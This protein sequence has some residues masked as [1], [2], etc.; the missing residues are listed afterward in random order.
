VTPLFIISDEKGREIDGAFV[1]LRVRNG[2]V[3]SFNMVGPEF[4]T[5]FHTDVLAVLNTSSNETA[6]LP[7]VLMQTPKVSSGRQ[8]K[9][10]VNPAFGISVLRE[11]RLVSS[12]I[13]KKGESLAFDG[14]SIKFADLDYWASFYV[15]KEHG[16]GIVYAGF[17]FMTMALFIRFVFFRRDIRGVSESGKL[18]IA[19]R[20]EF[21]PALFEDEFRDII[22]RIKG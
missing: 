21:F 15:G 7:Q 17:I 5:I 22:Q 11:G 4:Q 20:A 1:K 18:H 16:L 13:L 9:E 10:I 6:N 12:G 2:G 14:Y 19:G 3:D 8:H